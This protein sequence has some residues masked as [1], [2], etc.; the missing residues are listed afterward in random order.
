[1]PPNEFVPFLQ[2]LRNPSE[3]EVQQAEESWS[4][5]LKMVRYFYPFSVSI[6]LKDV[7]QVGRGP[8]GFDSVLCL[9]VCCEG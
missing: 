2:P 7:D 5:W 8:R 4:D 9:I 6:L 3:L 1:M